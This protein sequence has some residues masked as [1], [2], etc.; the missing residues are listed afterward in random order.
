MDMDVE[1]ADFIAYASAR[2]SSS[3]D[4]SDDL[5]DLQEL[6]EPWMRGPVDVAS[7]D[8]GALMAWYDDIA[9][10]KLKRQPRGQGNTAPSNRTLGWETWLF[11]ERKSHII[12][13]ED[14]LMLN[15]GIMLVR[16]SVWSWYFFQK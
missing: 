5:T 7:N 9:E 16:A 12:A 6:L 2:Q 4:D 3:V 8:A 11:D 10:K 15:T 13:S 14:G 1:L